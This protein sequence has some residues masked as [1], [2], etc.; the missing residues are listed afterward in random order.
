MTTIDLNIRLLDYLTLLYEKIMYLKFN[1][2]L[3]K[4]QIL[5]YILVNI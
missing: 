1:I 4:L 3:E 2:S 5:E